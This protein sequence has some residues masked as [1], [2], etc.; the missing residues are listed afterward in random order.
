MKDKKCTKCGE[1]KLL[2]EFS[3]RN[4]DKGILASNCKLCQKKM[5]QSYYKR[6]TKKERERVY[7]RKRR[8]REEFTEYKKSLKCNRCGFSHPAAIQFHHTDPTQKDTDLARAVNNGWSN[9]RLA[10]EIE[11]CEV[12]CANCHAIEHSKLVL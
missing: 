3:W 7:L 2:E 11:K 1:T 5:R 12:L 9:K 8:L 4:K 10:E 6:N